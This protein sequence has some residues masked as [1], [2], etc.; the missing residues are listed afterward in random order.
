M[1]NIVIWRGAILLDILEIKKI[2]QVL[3]CL[4]GESFKLNYYLLSNDSKGQDNF[5]ITYFS[6]IFLNDFL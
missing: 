5:D 6:E 4:Y 3:I 1:L 2:I